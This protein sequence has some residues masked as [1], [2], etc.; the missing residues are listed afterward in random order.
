MWGPICP[1]YGVGATAVVGIFGEW[2]PYLASVNPKVAALTS[3]DGTL[4]W[5]KIFLIAAIGSIFLEFGTSWILEKVFHAVWW[6]YSNVPLNIQGRV[7]L[8]AT[9]GFGV[10]GVAIAKILVPIVESAS[11]VTDPLVNEI[12]ALLFMFLFGMD[13]ALTVASLSRLITRMENIQKEFD[14]RLEAGVNVIQEGPAAVGSAVVTGAKAATASVKG[15]VT[16]AAQTAKNYAEETMVSR[17]HALTDNLSYRDR[18]HFGSIEQFRTRGTVGV[19]QRVKGLL[20][21][22]ES[23]ISEVSERR[24]EEATPEERNIERKG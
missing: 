16:G 13:F 23:R 20:A 4:P 7:C 3:Q 5:W 12:A 8:P 19:A 1:I 6:D 14:A 9:I 18:Y 10:A 21:G 11:A 22:M 17:V 24:S 2:I 15:A